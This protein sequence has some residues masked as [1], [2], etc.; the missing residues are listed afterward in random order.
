MFRMRR[1]DHSHVPV[2]TTA[3]HRRTRRCH[4]ALEGLE[5][6]WLLSSFYVA[7]NGSDSADGSA[8][9]PWATIQHAAGSVAAGDTV[10]VAQ[11]TYNGAIT[12]NASGTSSARI[13]FISD[14]P[15]GARVRSTGAEFT[16][17]NH[18]SYVDIQGFDIS[19]DGRIGLLNYVANVR[20]VGNYVHDIPALNAGSNGGA[21]IDN[22]FYGASNSLISGNVVKNI[23]T[24]PGGSTVQ[25]IYMSGS[26]DTCINNIVSN[27]EAFGIHLWHAGT[28]A[29]IVNNLSFANGR[30]GIII[31]AGDSPGGVTADNCVVSNNISINNHG[32][33]IREY[34]ATGI[35][36]RYL[37]NCVYGNASGGFHLHNGLTATGTVTANAQFVNYQAD[38]S[39][40]YHLR[41]TSPCIDHGTSTGA[42]TT[43]YDGV[44]RPQGAGFDI[45]PYEWAPT[46]DTFADPGFE[47]V[48]VGAGQFRY[49]PTGSPWTFSGDAGISGNGSGFT[50]GNPDAPE[51]VQVAFLQ[52]TGSF[53]QAVSGWAAGTY[54]L[55]FD[56]AQRGNF[57]TSRQDFDVLVDGVV[58]GTFTPSGTSYQAYTTA[59]FTVAAGSHTIVFRGLDSAG[60][61]NTAFVD[62]VTPVLQGTG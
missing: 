29:T 56:A 52:E 39:G 27:V 45:G 50:S 38:G 58:V 57:G 16:W 44:A 9:H 8:L 61:D 34:G 54:T 49:R 60:G 2:L 17:T 51:G 5:D 41:S 40:D 23:G 21:G 36:N 15:W 26:G 10:H 24:I 35:H 13:K 42:P 22:A 18:G 48:S 3:S 4:P 6:R 14:T 19:G 7:P 43:D 37:N 59:A 47:Q 1:R 46:T 25:G 28:N 62:A 55:T 20:I 12:T 33:G 31:G 53:S 32:Y 30:G 11:G